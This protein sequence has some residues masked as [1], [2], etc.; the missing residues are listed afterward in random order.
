MEIEIPRKK[1]QNKQWATWQHTLHKPCFLNNK[2]SIIQLIKAYIYYVRKKG[3]QQRS[4]TF[5]IH[6]QIGCWFCKAKHFY[7][8]LLHTFA[9]FSSILQTWPSFLKNWS[10]LIY[11][12]VTQSEVHRHLTTHGDP[13]GG[14]QGK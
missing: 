2:I 8:P 11:S 12:N 13:P 5:T 9:H 7:F 10:A 4:L 1:Y 3:A 14:P 6:A